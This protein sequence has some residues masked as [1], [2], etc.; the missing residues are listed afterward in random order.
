MFA[1]GPP[2]APND[3]RLRVHGAASRT[4]GEQTGETL[5]PTLPGYVRD[6]TVPYGIAVREDLL[7]QGAGHSYGEM[8]RPL[9]TE[10][11]SDDE[12][13]DVLVLATEIPDIRF[14]RSTATYLG[15]HCPGNPL[16]F[17]VCDQGPLAAFT[18][19]H[20][21]EAY[22]RTNA[23]RRAVLLIAEQPT[24]YHE[25]PV[26]TPL[27]TQAAAVGLVLETTGSQSTLAV[28]RKTKLAEHQVPEALAELLPSPTTL[29]GP[30]LSGVLGNRRTAETQPLTGIWSELAHRLTDRRRGEER[31]LL[32]EYDPAL[33]Y[34]FSATLGNPST[35]R[36]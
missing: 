19:L 23:C 12:P 25:L 33:G 7:E 1:T 35:S 10:L 27:P 2:A 9:L 28:Q 30:H 36:V 29:L 6:M 24:L 13:A 31:V 15:W 5:N 22:A 8:C 20:L 34:L 18:A 16:A 26:P 32:A 11:L 14:G 21:I 4:Y 17:T 3:V